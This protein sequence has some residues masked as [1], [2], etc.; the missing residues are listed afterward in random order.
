MTPNS[1]KRKYIKGEWETIN[2]RLKEILNIRIDNRKLGKDR[3]N[4][5][6]WLELQIDQ[7]T[8]RD[9]EREFK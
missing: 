4:E 1:D 6:H 2:R 3:Q 5:S 8:R 7:R 9:V